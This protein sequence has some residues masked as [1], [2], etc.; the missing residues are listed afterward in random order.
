MKQLVSSK[1]KENIE[2]CFFYR[3]IKLC[4]FVVDNN[5]LALVQYISWTSK[6]VNINKISMLMNEI[7]NESYCWLEG[8]HIL[9]RD[10]CHREPFWNLTENKSLVMGVRCVCLVD[11]LEFNCTLVVLEKWSWLIGF[12]FAMY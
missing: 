3:E 5:L 4:L 10:S 2:I 1:Q 7:T 11:L 6:S 9:D 12:W 8:I